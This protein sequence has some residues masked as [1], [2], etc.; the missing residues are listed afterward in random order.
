MR[1]IDDEQVSQVGGGGL[2]LLAALAFVYYEREHIGDFFEGAF[3][4]YE[5]NQKEHN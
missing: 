1:Q 2:A 3:E 5:N 4:G